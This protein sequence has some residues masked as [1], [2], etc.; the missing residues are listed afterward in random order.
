MSSL[1]YVTIHTSDDN[2]S[3]CETSNDVSELA[4]NSGTF[5]NI[6]EH[7]NEIIVKEE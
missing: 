4:I 1:P 6:L 2:G 7:D 3:V 5:S